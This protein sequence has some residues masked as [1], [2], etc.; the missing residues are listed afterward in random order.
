MF[1]SISSCI[2]LLECTPRYVTFA[3]VGKGSE[4]SFTSPRRTYVYVT[5][6]FCLMT[7]FI[8]RILFWRNIVDRR[9]LC[10]G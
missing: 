2:K 8:V 5:A 3:A 4:F 6:V 10:A 9:K 1:F 7:I